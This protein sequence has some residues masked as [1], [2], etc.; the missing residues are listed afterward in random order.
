MDYLVSQQTIS[1]LFTNNLWIIYS[2][3]KDCLQIMYYITK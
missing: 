3:Y 2:E 1:G